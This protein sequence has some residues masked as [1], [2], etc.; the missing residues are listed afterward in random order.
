VIDEAIE[1]TMAP[2]T[3]PLRLF[4]ASEFIRM[5]FDFEPID[6]PEGEQ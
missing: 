5:H 3:V 2:R 6:G 1:R 4:I